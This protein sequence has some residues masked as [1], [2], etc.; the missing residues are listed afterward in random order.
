MKHQVLSI[1]LL[2]C[3]LALSACSKTSDSAASAPTANTNTPAQ[4][5]DGPRIARDPLVNAAPLGLEVGYANVDGV[6]SKLGDVTSL[7]DAGTNDYSNGRMFTADGSHLGIDGLKSALFIF[8]QAN[9]LQGVVLL[10]PRGPGHRGATADLA[11]TLGGKYQLVS[12]RFESFLDYGT[13]HFEQGDSRVDIDSPHLSFS[14]TVRYATKE[15]IATY[16]AS[17]D[18]AAKTAKESKEALL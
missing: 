12:K 17:T 8:D 5:H 14:M 9:T 10:M 6:R 1:T 13:F 15:F 11:K 4:E 2:A 18:Q 16:E 7:A 3:T